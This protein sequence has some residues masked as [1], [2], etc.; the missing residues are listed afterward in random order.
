MPKSLRAAA[1]AITAALLH[2]QSAVNAATQ[3]I[4]P[5]LPCDTGSNRLGMPLESVGATV[6]VI[7]IALP[8][9]QGVVSTA[10]QQIL[11]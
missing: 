4:L 8:Y 10:T 1:L 7:T 2:L 5:V 6:L 9:L 3:Q 11:F